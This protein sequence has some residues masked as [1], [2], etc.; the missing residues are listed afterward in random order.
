MRS[1]IVFALSI[2]LLVVGWHAL[3]RPD[4]PATIETRP[5]AFAVWSTYEG[6]L[7]SRVPALVTSRLRTSAAIV[8]LVGDGTRVTRGTVLARLDVSTL[9]RDLIRLEREHATAKA[10]LGNLELAKAPLELRDLDKKLQEA[11]I[12][13]EGEQRYLLALEKSMAAGVTPAEDVDRQKVRVTSMEE[14]FQTASLRRQLT[15]G[16]IHPASIADARARRDA[17]ELELKMAKEQLQNGVIRAP[18]DGVVIYRPMPL[19]SEFRGVRIGDTIYPNQPFMSITDMRDLIVQSPVPE[20]E[21]GLAR[22][23]TQAVVNPVALPGV[24]LNG[25]VESVSP[26][27]QTAAGRPSWEKYFSMTVAL[28]EWNEQLRPGMSVTV[29]VLS[30]FRPDAIAIPRTAVQW[31]DGAAYVALIID[32]DIVE[33]PVT[34]GMANDRDV[35]VLEGLSAGDRLLVP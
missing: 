23:G 29:Q 19:G 32:G 30:H 9:E 7:E 26:M 33:R 15:S 12:N 18:V 8:E 4:A 24:R 34:T 22:I 10:E 17:V 27:A 28:K 2:V 3:S 1:A 20:A 31:R 35:E 14:E 16:Q 13:L 5:A 11:K 21:F 6:M 25:V